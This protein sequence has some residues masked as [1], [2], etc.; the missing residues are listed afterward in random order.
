MRVSR[1]PLPDI[2]SPEQRSRMM[3]GIRGK[4]T[5]P[6]MVLRKGL[7]ALGFRFRLHDRKLPGTPDLVFP[8]YGAIIFVHGCFWHGHDCHLFRLPGTRTEFWHS[9]IER[10]RTVDART[11]VALRDSGWRVGT[12]WECAIRGKGRIPLEDVLDTCASWLKSTTAELEIRGS[13]T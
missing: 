9:K 11:V 1:S 3:A 12:V 5:K 6:E 7:H 8:R 10:N 4:D 2:V 13:N